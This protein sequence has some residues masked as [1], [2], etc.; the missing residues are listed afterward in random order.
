[1]AKAEIQQ[2]VD[3]RW[4]EHGNLPTVYANHAIVS[5]AGGNEFYLIFGEAIP[6]T[7]AVAHG[8]SVERVPIRPVAKVALSPSTMMRL[9]NAVQQNVARFIE[10]AQELEEAARADQAQEADDANAG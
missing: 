9:A 6:P 1:M 7:A 4:E 10:T 3:L 8:E 2:V 5:H